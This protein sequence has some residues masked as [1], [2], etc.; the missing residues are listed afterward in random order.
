M[1][2]FFSSWLKESMGIC[3]DQI[4]TKM[5]E[6]KAFG[7]FAVRNDKC[8]GRTFLAFGMTSVSEGHFCSLKKNWPYNFKKSQ[9]S[10][11][12]VSFSPA[13]QEQSIH[14]LAVQIRA[15]TKEQQAFGHLIGQTHTHTLIQILIQMR[16]LIFK[17]KFPH[18]T[19]W[20]IIDCP[21]ILFLRILD[22]L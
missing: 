15:K 1:V 6:Q 9:S 5:S 17:Y 20:S 12:I 10:F 21:I 7:H 22:Y 14:I 4:G 11:K 16:V 13:Q 18:N 3:E 2:L 8:V 19:L